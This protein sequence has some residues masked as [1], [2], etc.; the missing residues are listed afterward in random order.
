M[1]TVI[2]FIVAIV[3]L[4]SLH[5]LGHLVV[6]RLCGVKVL[7]FSIGFGKP[8]AC[9]RRGGIEWCLAPIP[10]GGYVR[11]VDTREGEVNDADL[12]YAFDQQHPLKR[13]AIVLA[14]P[15]TNLILA[16]LLYA[17]SFNIGGI[18]QIK[19]WIG[20]VESGSIAANAGFQPE[21]QIISVNN[22]T[23]SDWMDAQTKIMMGLDNG[24]VRVSVID[25]HQHPVV[26]QF[27]IANTQAADDVAKSGYL[28]MLPFKMINRIGVVMPG[29]IAQEAGLQVG[30]VLLS[31]NGMALSDW[32]HWVELIR[33]KAGEKLVIQYR[34]A[35]Q[36]LT[37]SLRPESIIEHGVIIGRVGIGAMRDTQWDEKVSQHIQ[38][39]LADSFKLAMKRTWDYIALT[40]SFLGKLITGQAS[41]HYL[42]G[43]LTIADVAGKTAAMGWQS[44]TEFL[45][46]VSVSLGVLNL[47]PIPVL[48][49][50]HFLYY[51]IEW[52]RGRPLNLR[53]QQL[54]VRFG[55]AIML[56]LMLVAFFNDIT[57]LFG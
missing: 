35:D 1:L 51:A 40:V 47:L 52:L 6:A 50:G 36:I 22:Q 3:V 10:L 21:D 19:P 32:S 46:L 26:R 18:T 38:P 8:F 13:I 16:V 45:A 42:S 11:M 37:T 39:N 17:L 29:S 7:R 15:I 55:L 33:A 4:V 5:E 23:V 30:D 14:G 53:T 41:L 25:Q 20:T 27:D 24:I 49:G 54:G 48:D 12:P 31:V 28:G 43:P 57:R 2:A 44:Y 56:M 9:I 34:R